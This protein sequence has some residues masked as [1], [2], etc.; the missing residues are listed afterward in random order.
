MD[1]SGPLFIVLLFL[2]VVFL[3]IGYLSYG[4]LGL[5][6]GL[7]FVAA[8]VGLLAYGLWIGYHIPSEG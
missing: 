7:A 3:S 1:E 8:G 6:T 5:T 2:S 4:F